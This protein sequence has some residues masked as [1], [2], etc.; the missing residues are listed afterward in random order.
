M[1][2]FAFRLRKDER[3]PVAPFLAG[4][5][6]EFLL[7]LVLCSKCGPWGASACAYPSIRKADL[8][9]ELQHLGSVPLDEVRW[10]AIRESM[11]DRLA[12]DVVLLPGAGFGPLR[13]KAP[14]TRRKLIWRSDWCFLLAESLFSKLVSDGFPLRGVP[15]E[16]GPVVA[17]RYVEIEARPT[18]E[19]VSAD[20]Q[21]RAA[22]ACPACGR[23][24]VG[25]PAGAFISVD[26]WRDTV[27]VGRV[28]GHPT[29]LIVSEAL[30]LALIGQGV[31]G[32]TLDRIPLQ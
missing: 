18:G 3:I 27:P 25:E 29:Q 31:T 4:V 11:R 24:A 13:G 21:F 1:H 10:Q 8:P 30:G 16:F 5:H 12:Q 28:L 20:A 2:G 6:R 15:A 26:S 17:E 19:L 7:P 23:R 32:I 14:E 9:N 22:D